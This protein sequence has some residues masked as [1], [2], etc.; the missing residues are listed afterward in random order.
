M[1]PKPLRLPLLLLFVSI[2]AAVTI[3]THQYVRR[4]VLQQQVAQAEGQINH[5][6]QTLRRSG[7]IVVLPEDDD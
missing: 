2:A 7:H 5:L 6:Q 1:I 3:V 4:A